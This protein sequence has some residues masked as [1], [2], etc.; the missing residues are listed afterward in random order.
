MTES[1]IGGGEYAK[2]R[3]FGKIPALSSTWWAVL[4]VAGFTDDFACCKASAS[5]PHVNVS[6]CIFFIVVVVVII[7]LVLDG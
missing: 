1:L 3:N 4:W 7:N 5:E 6:M 2:S